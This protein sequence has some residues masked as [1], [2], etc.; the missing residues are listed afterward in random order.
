MYSSPLVCYSP[1]DSNDK[2]KD[3]RET[4]ESGIMIL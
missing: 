4:V 2:L 3:R 1:L